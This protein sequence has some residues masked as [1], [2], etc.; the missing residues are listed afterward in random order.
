MRAGQSTIYL[1]L[2]LAATP[3]YR[4]GELP[5]VM[6]EL[7]RSISNRGGGGGG[8]RGGRGG[9]SHGGG[10]RVDLNARNMPASVHIALDR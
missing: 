3:M 2:D 10:N 9:Y 5:E 6:Q 4:S 8:G 7:A 1:N